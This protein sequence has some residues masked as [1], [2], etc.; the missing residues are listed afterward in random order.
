MN[1]IKTLR[2]S[3]PFQTLFFIASFLL[4]ALSQAGWYEELAPLTALFGL[5]G[6]FILLATIESRKSRFYLGGLWGL[7]VHGVG[8]SWL[9]Q[10]EVQG[11]Y[12][13]AVYA[14][15]VLLLA[16]Q[17]A[18]Y[19]FVFS[20]HKLSSFWGVVFLSGLWVLLEWSRSFF[21][22]GFMWSQA[23]LFLSFHPFSSQMLSWVGL[24]GLSYW[25]VFTNL[26]V[27]RFFI[28]EKRWLENVVLILAIASAPYIMGYMRLAKL[29]A[30]YKGADQLKVLLVQ[31]SLSIGQKR[32]LGEGAPKAMHPLDQW[33]HAFRLLAPYRDKQ[34]DL[35]VFPEYF[36]PHEAH[37]A[38][39]PFGDVASIFLE[40]F[41]DSS[42][43]K[44]PPVSAFSYY[45]LPGSNESDKIN[46]FVSNAFCA[47]SLSN[48]FGAEIVIGLDDRE[49]G[50]EPDSYKV[51]SSAFHF[52]PD[53][54]EA[55]RYDKR[56]LLPIAEYIPF[57]W[58]HPIA[59][60]YDIYSSFE[61]GEVKG[62]I[63]EGKAKIAPLICYEEL[64][65]SLVR[66]YRDRGADVLVSIINDAWYPNTNLPKVHYLHAR[67]RAIE[68]GMPLLRSCNTG[69]TVAVDALGR[70]TGLYGTHPGDSEW[71]PGILE[72]EV[73]L[74]K[75][76]TLYQRYGE[77]PVLWLSLIGLLAFFALKR[78]G[79]R[80]EP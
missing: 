77:Q 49:P 41:G 65:G 70:Q 13:Y 5:A 24:L 67:P 46:L 59:E 58:L 37:I 79:S 68:M 11:Q 29:D 38:L 52:K 7:L 16:L 55:D 44:F 54:L 40:G 1:L 63:F 8:I 39:Y 53:Q 2:A 33:R 48:V 74:V 3:L 45:T 75:F 60:I 43:F 19:A 76:D 61:R 72:V 4:V 15:L 32:G 51:Y 62:T 80:K 9:A 30:Q 21:F 66:E 57:E 28:L 10:D 78:N 69:V 35:I 34:A 22:T 47:Q 27:A 18:F 36:I 71:Q 73:P 31:P 56:L 6:F 64:F 14:L 42:T 12:I 50:K 20:R 17:T 23:G 26:L 25:V